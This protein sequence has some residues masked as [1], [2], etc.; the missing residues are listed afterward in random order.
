MYNAVICRYHE[1]AIKG[2]N[3]RNFE[4]Q[5]MGNMQH[6]LKSIANLKVR[7]VRGRIWLEHYQQEAFSVDELEIIK[8]NL[9]FMF[10]MESFS[11]AI[12]VKSDM[13]AIESA[14]DSVLDDVVLPRLAVKPAITFRIRARRSN[15][16][17]PLCS[18]DIE[19]ALATVMGDRYGHDKVKVHLDDDAELTVGCEVRDEFTVLFFETF[20][21]GGGLPVGSNSPV[22][23]L[24]SGGIDSP[25]ACLL[26]M[27]RGSEVDFMSFHSAPYTPQDTVDKVL[28]IG[29]YLNKFQRKGTHYFANIN[30]IQKMIRDNCDPHFRTILYRRMMFRIAEM[31]AK[32]GRAKALLTGESLGQV[33]SQTVENMS[34]INAAATMLV[35]RPLVGQDK[36]ETIQ[37]AEKYGT[38]DLSKV[39]VPDSCTVFAPPSPAT[40]SDVS[41]I[42]REEELLGD[43]QAVLQEIVDKIEVY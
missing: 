22:M 18:K 27:K 5:L 13:A 32:K 35:L 25:V 34:T 30:S 7:S 20:R 36:L 1:I 31:V 11:P 42:E 8:E 4:R 17:F 29:R 24:L 9:R 15:K 38:F 12:F 6:S 3:R 2:H 43:Y 41:R 23:A 26:T 39:Q 19:I 16:A 37:L 21:S 28:K 10:G 14:L 40:R 33:A